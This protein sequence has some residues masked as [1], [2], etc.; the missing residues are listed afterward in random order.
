MRARQFRRAIKIFAADEAGLYDKRAKVFRLAFHIGSP[1][2]T[3]T[4]DDPTLALFGV[5]QQQTRLPRQTD[6]L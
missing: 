6:D 1:N 4:E 5:N 2:Q 3:V